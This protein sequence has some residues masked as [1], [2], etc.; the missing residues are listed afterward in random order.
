MTATPLESVLRR[1]RLVVLAALAALTA[2]SLAYVAWLSLAMS[3]M[4]AAA[5]GGDMTGMDMAGMD[6]S[7]GGSMAAA[8]MPAF[9]AWGA[10]DFAFIFAMWTVMMVGMMTPSAAPM[11]LLYAMAGRRLASAAGTPLAATGWFFAGYLLV[12]A[13]FSALATLAQWLLARLAL[14]SPMM[15]ASDRLLG[16][17]ILLA[18]GIYQWTPLKTACLR[19]CRGPFDFLMRHGGFREGAFG[20]LRIGARH[21]LYCLGCCFALMALLFVGGVMNLLWIA[22]LA[23]L[24]LAEKTLPRGGVLVARLAGVLLAAAGLWLIAGAVRPV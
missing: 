22:G 21:G 16:G 15:V 2:L 10:G 11:V 23:I 24:V 3:A 7:G 6:M 8:M 4:P 12:W 18:A 13:G 1:D 9:A 5:P 20:A 14:L 19:A 17:V